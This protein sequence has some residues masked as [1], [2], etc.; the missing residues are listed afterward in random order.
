MNVEN[1]PVVTN[2]SHTIARRV[3]VGSQL[4]A[5]DGIPAKEYLSERVIPAVSETTTRRLLDHAV[6][7]LLLGSQGSQVKCQF[8]SPGDDT[9]EMELLRNRRIDPDPWLRTSGVPDQ[10][11]FMVFNEWLFEGFNSE[12]PFSAFEFRILEGNVAYVALNSFMHPTVAASFKE[13]L[14]T[15]NRCSG[16]VLD[17]RKNHGGSDSVPASTNGNAACPLA[18][19]DCILP[20]L[21]G[22]HE[23]YSAGQSL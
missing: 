9:L 11:E 2:A 12:P 1:T 6:A 3:P 13:K 7:R 20:V 17:L 14:P 16:L 22:D 8:H 21:W 23:R 15:I 19:I 10:W 18:P 4:L 5:I